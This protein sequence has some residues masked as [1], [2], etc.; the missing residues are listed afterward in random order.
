MGGKTVSGFLD[1]DLRVFVGNLATD[2]VSFNHGAGRHQWDV[3]IQEMKVFA[4]VVN[5]KE[6]LNS[7]AIYLVKV[8]IVLQ[9]QRIFVPLKKGTAYYTI[10]AIIWLNG[11]YYLVTC[12][13]GILT[14]IP[15]R[16]I[17]EPTTPGHCLNPI[18]WIVASGLINVV[19]DFA[20]LMIPIFCISA[21]QM[22]L[23]RK[24]GISVVFAIGLFA[25]A[26]S[27]VRAVVSF[28]LIGVTDQTWELIPLA[29]W[30]DAEIAS[31]LI[32][33]S[34]PVLPQL[35]RRL[36]PVIKSTFASYAHR[37]PK[38][39]GSS[40]T[41]GAP[42]WPG[43]REQRTCADDDPFNYIDTPRKSN[44]VEMKDARAGSEETILAKSPPAQSRFTEGG[45]HPVGGD[46]ERGIIAH[47]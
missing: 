37:H 47:R 34:V 5:A 23:K 18:N 16:K 8:S 35:I 19:S 42:S 10:Q 44:Y 36:A 28:K 38:H 41:L 31:G 29:Y 33:V 21:L 14:C 13:A 9:F 1:V 3:P 46:L 26:T 15:R 4:Q 43:A 7:P 20:I 17:W 11:I 27:I 12:L 2:F 45:T 39:S 24:V 30:S 25:C 40:H 6:I 22:P 32:C